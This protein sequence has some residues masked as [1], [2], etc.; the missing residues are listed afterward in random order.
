MPSVLACPGCAANKCTSTLRRI[1]LGGRELHECLACAGLWLDTNTVLALE[2]DAASRAAFNASSATA[3]THTIMNATPANAILQPV[4]YRRCPVCA[5]VM[6]RVNVARISGVVVD[7]C[8]EHGTYFD[9]DE[10]HQLVRFLEGGGIDRARTRER[11][12]LA[13]ERRQMNFMR[14]LERRKQR[15]EVVPESERG[16]PVATTILALL[17][18]KLFERH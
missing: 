12:A 1:T 13:D 8:H 2:T 15:F 11:Q 10:L 18:N 6:G 17:A 9:V 14:D 3:A 16:S 7:R 4:R 5:D